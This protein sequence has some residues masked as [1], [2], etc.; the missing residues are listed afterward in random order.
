MKPSLVYVTTYFV[1]RKES[2]IIRVDPWARLILTQ[3]LK[4]WRLIDLLFCVY[5][6]IDGQVVKDI[7]NMFTVT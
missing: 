5:L 3:V 4:L 1:W 6:V 7:I 2:F